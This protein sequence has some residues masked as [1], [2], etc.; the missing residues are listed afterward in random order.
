MSSCTALLWR[1]SK[2]QM[3]LFQFLLLFIILLLFFQIVKHVKKN[4]NKKVA[5]AKGILRS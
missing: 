3:Q 1:H 2:E 4:K 5:A